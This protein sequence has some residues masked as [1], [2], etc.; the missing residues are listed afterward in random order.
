MLKYKQGAVVW[1]GRLE[2]GDTFAIGSA[3]VKSCGEAQVTLEGYGGPAFNYRKAIPVEEV[4]P[5]KFDA[6]MALSERANDAIAEAE[7]RLKTE[8]RRKSAIVAAMAKV[9]ANGGGSAA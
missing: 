5:S 1:G 2:H 6:L 4:Y 7:E 9:A 8:K 3:V